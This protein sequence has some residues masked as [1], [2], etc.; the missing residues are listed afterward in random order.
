MSLYTNAKE[1]L[2]K[3][4]SRIRLVVA[5]LIIATGLVA[6][7]TTPAHAQGSAKNDVCAGVN[8]GGGSCNSNGSEISKVV[9]TVVNI[10]SLIAGIAAVIM[11]IVGG[12]R[13]ITS[14]GDSS[15]VASAKSA[16]IYSIVG[17]IIV[18]LAQFIVRYVLNE[19]TQ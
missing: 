14:G 2:A 9:A 6:G 4:T 19:A 18:A 1:V 7:F 15:K 11:I 10:L 3:S 12:L 17:L 13:Y 5:S 8:L 16:I